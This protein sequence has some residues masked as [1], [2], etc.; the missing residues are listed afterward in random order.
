MTICPF[1]GHEFRASPAG[2]CAGCP[3]AGACAV[4]CCPRCGYRTPAESR[5]GKL[6]KRLT[7]KGVANG[8]AIGATK[9]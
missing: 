4:S 8:E 3:M 5:L 9:R 7:K 1:C 2:G 6:L